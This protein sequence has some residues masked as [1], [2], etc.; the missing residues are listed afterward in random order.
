MVRVSATSCVTR[1]DRGTRA[2]L[3][4]CY[5][6]TSPGLGAAMAGQLRG[7]LD[8][9]A[10]QR[11]EVNLLIL[12]G[13]AGCDFCPAS[14]T[15]ASAVIAECVE[16]LH[17]MTVPVIAAVDK[18]W[19]D[20]GVALA[21]ACD[22]VIVTDQ[23]V[24]ALQPAGVDEATATVLSERAGRIRAATMALTGASLTGVQAQRAGIAQVCVS[25][26]DFE[27]AVARWTDT[28]GTANAQARAFIETAASPHT[29]GDDKQ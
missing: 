14:D 1:V 16:N 2:E 21:L 23:T 5:R 19:A 10:A 28:F 18:R 12:R 25:P 29:R 8:D 20:A 3:R 22:I 7:H 26:C 11:S 9:I 13:E 17:M 24:L 4:F 15:D 27:A 6:G